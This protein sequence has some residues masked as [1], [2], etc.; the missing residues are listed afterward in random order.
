[1][2][3]TIKY[4]L[5]NANLKFTRSLCLFSFLTMWIVF[6][7]RFYIFLTNN[8]ENQQTKNKVQVFQKKQY[9]LKLY[10]TIHNTERQMSMRMMPVKYVFES[11]WINKVFIYK[12]YDFNFN[13]LNSFYFHYII[14]LFWYME[15]YFQASNSHLCF[16][17][18]FSVVSNSKY[19][20]KKLLTT[21]KP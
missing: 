20:I 7:L 1:M 12:P 18:V 14:S 3:R 6:F 16:I 13:Q 2:F 17:S 15:R 5:Q 10:R 4:F 21:F 19:A 11:I 9:N 8:R